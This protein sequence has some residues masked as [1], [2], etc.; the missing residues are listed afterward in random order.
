MSKESSYPCWKGSIRKG[1]QG[2]CHVLIPALVLGTQACFVCRYSLHCTHNL[3][4][5]GMHTVLG[6]K[7]FQKGTHL[8]CWWECKLV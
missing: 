6:I 1:S 5:F 4:V 8:H 7:S 2:C 3:C